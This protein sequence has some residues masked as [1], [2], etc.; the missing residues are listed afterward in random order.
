MP[1]SGRSVLHDVSS[2]CG[3]S[4]EV[5]MVI[6]AGVGRT[7]SRCA[8]RVPI[9]SPFRVIAVVSGYVTVCSY[10]MSRPY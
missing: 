7:M 6:L 9:L 4:D 5:C 3:R 1:V 2:P 10:H 8:V